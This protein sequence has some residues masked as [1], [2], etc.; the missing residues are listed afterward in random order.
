[1]LCLPMLGFAQNH[2]VTFKVSAGNITVGP[3]GLYVGGGIAGLANA[4]QLT[5]ADSNGVWE[6]SASL[7]ATGGYFAFF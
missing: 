3:N 2:T 5:D 1:M 7:P 4:V 6:G